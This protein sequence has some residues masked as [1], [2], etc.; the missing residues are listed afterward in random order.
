MHFTGN[1][2]RHLTHSIGNYAFHRMQP[3]KTGAQFVPSRMLALTEDVGVQIVR[4]CKFLL[5]RKLS[6]NGGL[7]PKAR[8]GED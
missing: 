5:A 7:L 1:G 4:S 3:R 8:H 2:V 6:R